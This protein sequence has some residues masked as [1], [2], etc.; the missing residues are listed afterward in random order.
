MLAF[1]F[2]KL[3]QQDANSPTLFFFY[4]AVRILIF[5]CFSLSPHRRFD[6]RHVIAATP[7]L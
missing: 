5:Y 6:H 2:F 7:L 1:A 4:P 3:K